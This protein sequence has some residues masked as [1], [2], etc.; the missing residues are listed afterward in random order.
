ML[1]KPLQ[2]KLL[3][4]TNQRIGKVLGETNK[5][6][7]ESTVRSWKKK[8]PE[9]YKQ[10]I[11]EYRLKKSPFIPKDD[12]KAI[13]SE[14]QL[15]KS[16]TLV[17]NKQIPAIYDKDDNILFPVNLIDILKFKEEFKNFNDCNVLSVANFKGG[18]GKTTTAINIAITLSFYGFR[19][20]LCDFDIQG[21]T[22]SM[23]DLYRYKKDERKVDLSITDLEVLY[24]IE[25][26]DFKYTII[27]LIAEVE[28]D[29]IDNIIRNSII[30]LNDRVHTIGQFDILPNTNSI[31]NS[32]KFE[33]ID[34]QLKTYGNVNQALDDVL[35]YVKNDYDFIII[36]TPPSISL[37]LRMSVLA[38][39]YF[40]I[41]LT[42]DK[43]SKDGIAPFVVPIE[44]NSKAYKRY[45]KKDIVVLGGI[46]NM[47]QNNINI[48]R[49]NK[50]LVAEDLANTI[51]NSNLGESSLFEQFIKRDNILTE[52]QLDMGAVLLYEPAHELVRD[53]FN[54]VD[55]IL[56]RILIDKY[57]K[58]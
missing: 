30:N 39:D 37:P 50:E 58:E 34:K 48:H 32:F 54:L 27:D 41:A 35:S 9:L 6:I 10:K 28:N 12:F 20:L 16:R 44:M 49:M 5:P 21:N 19:V 7:H 52:A 29:E 36:D 46:M 47:F 43:M 33:D 8:D 2:G 3:K 25:R 1:F 13:Y 57:S 38:T 31:E 56:E 45:K 42:P 15:K 18:V 23:F 14:P 51:E 24:D 4:P 22:T 26:S 40:L 17:L 11:L 55:E 53:Y